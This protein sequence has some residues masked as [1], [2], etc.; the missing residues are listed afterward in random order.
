MTT[1]RQRHEGGAGELLEMIGAG[2][3]AQAIHVAAELRLADLLADGPRTTADLAEATG[4]HEASL[5]RLLRA[6]TTIG[7]CTAPDDDS[8]AITEM[9]ALL[10]TGPGSL[11]SWAIWWG[12]QL[13]PVW[14]ELLTSVRTGTSAR[15]AVTGFEGFGQLEVEAATA[16]LFHDALTELTRLEAPAIIEAYDFSGAGR[17][18]D[19]GGGQGELLIDVLR[20]TPDLE[21]VLFDLPHALA[22]AGPRIEAAGLSSRCELVA[23]SFFDAVPPGGG[24]Y[25]LKSVIHDWTDDEAD[26]ILTNCRRAMG[27]SG[28]LVLVERVLPD[29]LGTTAAARSGVRSDLTM[30]LAQGGQER[31]E[32]QFRALLDSAGFRLTR[33]VAASPT[34]SVLEAV[35][36]P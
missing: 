26:A 29:P 12:T 17:V 11:R 5:A 31:T 8:F 30:L 13:W 2:W 25:V 22:G 1:E 16:A 19:V 14:G 24:A 35:P 21:G 10:G 6:L 36:Q 7:V 3:T 4:T 28:R 9:G 20:A 33:V 15:A 18:V 27:D 23:G 32:E 34:L